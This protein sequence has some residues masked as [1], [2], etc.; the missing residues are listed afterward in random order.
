MLTRQSGSHTCTICTL[1]VTSKLLE[2]SYGDILVIIAVGRSD[3]PRF[4]EEGGRLI[5]IGSYIGNGL[6]V[7]KTIISHMHEFLRQPRNLRYLPRN[8]LNDE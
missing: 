7:T 4:L 3:A 1:T 8:S 6:T 5:L 2:T